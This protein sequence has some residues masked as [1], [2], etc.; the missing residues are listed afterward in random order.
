[1]KGAVPEAEADEWQYQCRI[2]FE[3][4]KP[5]ELISPCRCKVSLIDWIRAAA[6]HISHTAMQQ[7]DLKVFQSTV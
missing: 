1:M 3:D 5:S 4:A 6:L 2:C 7:A